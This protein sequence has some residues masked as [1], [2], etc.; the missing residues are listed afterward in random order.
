MS[1]PGLKPWS[2]VALSVLSSAGA[3][4]AGGCLGALVYPVL[5]ELK[6]DWTEERV[7]GPWIILVL[8]VLVGCVCCLF[9]WTLTHLDS[10]G[11]DTGP[12]P[13]H[14]RDVSDPGGLVGSGVAGLNGLLA[15]LTVIWSLT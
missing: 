7:L 11:P 12:P 1:G 8:S 4:A 10:Y 6:A 15:M 9:S 2:A 14:L 5:T 3:A 13:T